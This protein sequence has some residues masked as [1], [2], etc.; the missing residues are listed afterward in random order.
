M[1]TPWLTTWKAPQLRQASPME[2]VVAESERERSM[3]GI[4]AVSSAALWWRLGRAS[5]GWMYWEGTTGMPPLVTAST[6]D[7][8][9]MEIVEM[10]M[11]LVLGFDYNVISD[12]R[13]K[14]SY[15]NLQKYPQTIVLFCKPTINLQK[16]LKYTSYLSFE[17]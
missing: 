15:Q 9:S 3:V 14:V 8:V 10:M 16:L 12:L 1:G 11:I 5:G 2:S 13:K 7:A 17:D 6:L 4:G